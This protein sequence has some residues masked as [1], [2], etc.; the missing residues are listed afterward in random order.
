ML[1]LGKSMNGIRQENRTLGA[2]KIFYPFLCT[3]NAEF[4]LTPSAC[5]FKSREGRGREKIGRLLSPRGGIFG[6]LTTQPFSSPTAKLGPEIKGAAAA[7][8]SHTF[9]ISVFFSFFL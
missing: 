2:K 8:A 6:P 4:G 1:P 3:V 9:F 5:H 7:V